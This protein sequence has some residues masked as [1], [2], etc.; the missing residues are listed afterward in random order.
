MQEIRAQDR[1]DG[2]IA[3]LNPGEEAK[4]KIVSINSTPTVADD[5]GAIRGDVADI[6]KILNN[7]DEANGRNDALRAYIYA[8]RDL[9]RANDQFAIIGRDGAAIDQARA[10]VAN[11]FDRLIAAEFSLNRSSRADD[12]GDLPDGE[13]YDR[14]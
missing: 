12:G 3:E 10:A 13:T 11:A 9:Q 5:D 14:R 7:V 4:M 2:E 6:G 8:L 1:R